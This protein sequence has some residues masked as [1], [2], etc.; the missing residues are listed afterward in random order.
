M[1]NVIFLSF[2]FFLAGCMTTSKNEVQVIPESQEL[3]AA[4]KS[5]IRDENPKFKDCYNLSVAGNEIHPTGRLVLR[6]IVSTA[7]QVTNVSRDD[8]T[9][10]FNDEKVLQCF[11]NVI[12]RI[13]FPVNSL[14]REAE[15]VFPFFLQGE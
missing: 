10:T 9:S 5:K 13:T 11:K 6:I 7:G 12:S 15:I 3:R 1:K 2:S 4:I 14:G 8:K